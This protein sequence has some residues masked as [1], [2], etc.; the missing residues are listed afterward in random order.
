MQDQNKGRKKASRP[1]DDDSEV[2]PEMREAL[3]MYFEK[4]NGGE[5]DPAV[6]PAA[7]LA[8][9]QPETQ[10]EWQR[11][12]AL[13]QMPQRY[14]QIGPSVDTA[15][16]RFR[17]RAFDGATAAETVS[18]GGYVAQNEQ[19]VIDESGLPSTTLEALKAD[20][21]PLSELKGY[22]I[23]DYADLAR[24]YGVEDSLF[25]RMLKWLKG[26]GK[27]LTA[28][29]SGSMRG[30]VFARDEEARQPG[31]SEAELSEELD[32]KDKEEE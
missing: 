11:T 27:G 20:P 25:P 14:S 32:K 9:G 18:L 29:S 12:M 10:T 2:A 30:M 23:N 4:L 5:V 16:Q 19:N 13:L 31:L 6:E 26:L 24:R 22:R 8:N 21:T 1:V 7:L 15:W 28:P 17:T 3:A